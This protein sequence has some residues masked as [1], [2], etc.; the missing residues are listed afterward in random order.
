MEFEA[1]NDGCGGYIKTTHFKQ[2]VEERIEKTQSIFHGGNQYTG[3]IF[4][5][6]MSALESDFN[7]NQEL[8][9]SRIGLCG[10]GSGAKA[11]VFEGIIQPEW[12][13]IASRFSL[14]PR[15]DDRQPI[16]KSIYE[17]LHR[18]SKGSS[19]ISPSGEFALISI[20]AEGH[21]EGEKVLLDKLVRI[22]FYH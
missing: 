21:L 15:I 22:I 20:G 2:F 12:K 3:S 5:A 10:Y 9:G 19:V 8:N 16:D 11:K 17:A 6:L 13:H 14:F 1:A 7:E 18:G 4:L